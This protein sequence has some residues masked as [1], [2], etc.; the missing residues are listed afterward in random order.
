[1]EL[2]SIKKPQV[3]LKLMK[4]MYIVENGYPNFKLGLIKNS[5]GI[6]E[7]T[8]KFEVDEVYIREWTSKLQTG[9]YQVF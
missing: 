5:R 7:S 6:K 3:S 4:Y 1:M 2:K 8:S 9:A